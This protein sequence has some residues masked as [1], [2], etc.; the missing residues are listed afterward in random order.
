M[1]QRKLRSLGSHFPLQP[2]IGDHIS[3]HVCVCVHAR[4]GGIVLRGGAEMHLLP[5]EMTRVADTTGAL[6]LQSPSLLRTLLPAGVCSCSYFS[7]TSV[8][9][10]LCLLGFLL[11]WEIPW[12]PSCITSR[13]KHAGCL[14]EGASFDPLGKQKAVTN[15]RGQVEWWF[16]EL[17]EC[18]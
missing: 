14:L 1:R 13:D 11:E 12:L 3:V 16:P 2:R 7:G 15:G 4:H 8:P 9:P 5:G 18:L 17:M 6:M 10:Q